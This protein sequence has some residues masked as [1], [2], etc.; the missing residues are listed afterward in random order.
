MQKF[1]LQIPFKNGFVNFY[2]GPVCRQFFTC[3][4]FIG[5]L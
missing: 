1:P 2:R 4:R 3:V 5:H